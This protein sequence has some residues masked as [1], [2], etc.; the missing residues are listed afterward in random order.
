M[1]PEKQSGER[2]FSEL[3]T[4]LGDSVKTTGLFVKG[5]GFIPGIGLNQQASNF[6]FAR[7]LGDVSNPIDVADGIL[8]LKIA[9]IKEESV[10]PLEDVKSTIKNK[11][12]TE[13][14]MEMAGQ[15]ANDVYAKIKNG[16]SLEEAAEKDT[17]LQV[18][19]SNA[20]K[21][22]GSVSKVGRD[23]KFMGTAAGLTEPGEISNP[24]EGTRGFYILE[25]IEK[26]P[27]DKEDF[28]EKKNQIAANLL[29]TKR[30]QAFSQWYAQAKEEADIEDYRYRFYY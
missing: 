22:T 15:K 21:L 11:L 3:V 28:Q 26:T 6:I 24:V 7:E 16:L 20:F 25:L 27:F 29:Q 1:Q 5:T 2:D 23:A 9:Q 10:K 14:R 17:S 30:N 4:E 13:K 12:L 8:V 19:T 18:E